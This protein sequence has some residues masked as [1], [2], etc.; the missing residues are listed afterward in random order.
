MAHGGT[1]PRRF[2]GGLPA[3]FVFSLVALVPLGLLLV[4]RR[5]SHV[6]GPAS[7]SPRMDR[8]RHDLDRLAE[9]VQSHLAR[10][11]QLSALSD[12]TRPE[13]DGRRS[14]DSLPLDPWGHDYLLRRPDKGSGFTVLSCGWDGIE[15][16]EDDLAVSRP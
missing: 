13:A 3:P 1:R 9:A 6:N 11:P 15:D 12:L 2:I 16:T 10:H 4:A 14:L 8:A 5:V 7:D